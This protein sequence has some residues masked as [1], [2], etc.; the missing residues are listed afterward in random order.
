MAQSIVD[1]FKDEK[2]ISEIEKLKSLGVKILEQE[3]TIVD[4]ENFFFNKKFVLTGTLEKFKRTEVTE[5]I[6]SFGGSVVGSV[7]KNTDFVLAGADA[8][9]KLEKAK[10][11][12]VAVLSEIEFVSHI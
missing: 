3:K 9:S 2:N 5:I 7:S 1:F 11:L 10:Q 4:K 8:G 12:N 6:E